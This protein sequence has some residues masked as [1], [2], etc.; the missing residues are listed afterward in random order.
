MNLSFTL[1]ANDQWLAQIF[2]AKSAHRGGIVRRIV[3]DV[4]RK[5]GR[6]RFENEVRKRGFHLLECDGQFLILC[7]DCHLK[8]IC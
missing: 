1:C 5:V 7:S 3:S 2:A 6:A 8:V 4:E